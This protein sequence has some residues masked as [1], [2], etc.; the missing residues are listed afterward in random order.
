M[1][2]RRIQAALG[3]AQVGLELGQQLPVLSAALGLRDEPLL[4]LQADVVGP[5]L[6]PIG[7]SR[8]RHRLAWSSWRIARRRLS[9]RR[10]SRRAP[11]ER[12]T[13]DRTR[14]GLAAERPP[15]PALSHG[16]GKPNAQG[17]K[18]GHG[19]QDEAQAARSRL[20][21]QHWKIPKVP[22]AARFCKER[23]F[24]KRP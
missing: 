9:R 20:P 24:C 8:W 7:L 3:L 15:V 17:S 16:V 23:R 21:V 2:L 1:D 22:Q 10:L 18:D 12:L 19:D 13:R 6:A 11:V 14:L 4:E 5:A